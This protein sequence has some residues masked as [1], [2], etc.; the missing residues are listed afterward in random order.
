MKVEGLRRPPSKTSM[1]QSRRLLAAAQA[2]TD[3]SGLFS[4]FPASCM[5]AGHT[6]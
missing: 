1:H 6:P 5:P 2:H 3:V 4:G